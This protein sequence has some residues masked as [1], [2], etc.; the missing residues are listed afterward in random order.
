[1]KRYL[2][3]LGAGLLLAG[4]AIIG[5]STDMAKASGGENGRGAS[6]APTLAI[7][8]TPGD[9]WH[10]FNFPALIGGA[11]DDCLTYAST[12][13]TVVTVTDAFCIGDEFHVYD[14]NALLG[15]TSSV[16]SE[17][18]ACS[19]VTDPDAAIAAGF[20]NGTFKIC[21]AG[22]HEICVTVKELW[23]PLSGGGAFFRVDP[24]TCTV[25]EA[26]AEGG[27]AADAACPT[28]GLYRNHGAYVSCVAAAT[29]AYLAT[30]TGFTSDELEEI[31]SCIVNPR[32]RSSV[33]K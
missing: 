12:G 3:N 5:P 6:A 15:D 2:R 32:A 4:F 27:A 19:N 13:A 8:I 20:S 9:G 31:S 33:G 10:F 23:N 30:L 28:G 18:P 17:D 29:N 24:A 1:M 14:N 7:P 22:A 26:C 16:L 11:G 25:A 21:A